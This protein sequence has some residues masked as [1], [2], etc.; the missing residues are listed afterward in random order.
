M[1][2]KFF[3]GA[4]TSKTQR[5]G[6]KWPSPPKDFARTKVWEVPI[7]CRYTQTT[8][9]AQE[10]ISFLQEKKTLQSWL[11]SVN[12]FQPHHPFLPSEEYSPNTRPKNARSA[13]PPGPVGVEACLSDG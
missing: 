11:M 10:A 12:I 13:V 6:V 1:V 2:T 9:C 5:Q 7:D 8:W 4:M 3:S